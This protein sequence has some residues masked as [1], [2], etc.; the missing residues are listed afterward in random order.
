MFLLFL[1]IWKHK[2]KMGSTFQHLSERILQLLDLS[3]QLLN[4]EQNGLQKPEIPMETEILG[5]Q[6]RSIFPHGRKMSVWK[7]YLAWEF[8][9][10][11]SECK[12]FAELHTQMSWQ[13]VWLPASSFWYVC[14]ILDELALSQTDAHF[15]VALYHGCRY[16]THSVS[17]L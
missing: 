17:T 10:L 5:L 12:K 14:L 2:I 3:W 4:T 13:G 8:L 11:C 6:W 9:S 7:T 16:Q 1:K 15:S